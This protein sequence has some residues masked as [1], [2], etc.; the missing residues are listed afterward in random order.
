MIAPLLSTIDAV[1][2]TNRP[3]WAMGTSVAVGTVDDPR[4][5]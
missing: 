1:A 2:A 3:V 4:L 5:A